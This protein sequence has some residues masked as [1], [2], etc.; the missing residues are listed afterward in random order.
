MCVCVCV[1]LAAGLSGN[2]GDSPVVAADPPSDA[3][4]QAALP[5]VVSD[6]ANS[7]PVPAEDPAPA[8]KAPSTL[9]P[10]SPYVMFADDASPPAV[11]S[12]NVLVVIQLLLLPAERQ[13]YDLVP[14]LSLVCW[15]RSFKCPCG[16]FCGSLR[17]ILCA[18]I[19]S[20]KH[21]SVANLYV[22][23]YLST[24]YSCL[25]TCSL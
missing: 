14:P 23:L 24:V 7:K 12:L 20:S 6:L 13:A 15:L 17:T 16:Y 2:V 10:A 3:P 1:E 21:T 18:Y 9:I 25:L 22:F 5:G 4:G 11:D 19:A 8:G